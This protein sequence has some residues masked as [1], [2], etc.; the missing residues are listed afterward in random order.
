MLFTSEIV[1]AFETIINAAEN[2]F[3]MHR[4][5]V[6]LRDLTAP[7][8]PEVIDDKHQKFNGVTYAKNKLNRYAKMCFVHRE[9]WEYYHGEIP[10]GYDI[11]H[12]DE[13]KDNNNI[14][15]L[16]LLTRAEHSHLHMQL[17]KTKIYTCKNCGK[18]FESIVQGWH[19]FCSKKCQKAYDYKHKTETK[20]CERCGKEFQCPKYKRT[21]FCSSHCGGKSVAEKRY[22][23]YVR[24]PRWEYPTEKRNCIICGKEFICHTNSKAQTCSPSCSN[25]LRWKNRRD[26][27]N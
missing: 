21:R 22:K 5:E 20:I 14:E 9:V 11:H 2:E 27:Q 25:K 23:D 3:E 16:Q 15:N 17:Y 13:V 19:L 1:A 8:K 7:P 4:I 18:E 24:K 12:I 26:N 10:E 6:L